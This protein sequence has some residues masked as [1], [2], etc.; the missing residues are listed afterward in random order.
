MDFDQDLNA[1][2]ELVERGD[3]DRFRAAMAAPVAARVTLF[4]LY[5]FNVEISRAPWV[6]EEPLIAEMR[7]QWWADALAEIEGG[8][9]VRRHEVVTPLAHVLDAEGARVLAAAVEARR[10]DAAREDVADEAALDGYLA[11]TGGALLWGAARALG[12][13]QEARARAVGL[14]LARANWCLGAA[15]LQRRGR[16]PFPRMEA[17][18]VGALVARW[19]DDRADLDEAPSKPQRLAELCAW[20]AGAVLKAAAGDPA[21]VME[22]RIGGSEVGKRVSL[23]L[24]AA[25]IGRV[26]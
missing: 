1:C 13:R 25:G 9:V 16:R 5:A 21:S 8:G 6:T 2:A 17:A 12:S 11:D 22:G 10:A 7:L 20:R 3:P 15:E 23:A 18:A 4:P 24:R 14:R 19:Q 26:A